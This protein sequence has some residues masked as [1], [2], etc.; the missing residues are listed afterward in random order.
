MNDM[1]ILDSYIKTPGG[2]EKQKKKC[3]KPNCRCAKG[4]HLHRAYCYRYWKFESGRYF[5]KRKYIDKET[6]IKLKEVLRVY[7][8]RFSHVVREYH[9]NRVGMLE[10]YCNGIK[11]DV[12]M[13]NKMAVP[14]DNL[15]K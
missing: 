14:M 9:L 3:G 11:P 10:F 8:T 1:Q 12:K 13:M 6:Y 7:K 4:T 15:L 5:R 2:V